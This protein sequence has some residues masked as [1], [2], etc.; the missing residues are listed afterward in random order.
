M[1]LTR[2]TDKLVSILDSATGAVPR[3]LNFFV[4]RSKLQVSNFCDPTTDTPTQV[5]TALAAAIAAA[6][7]SGRALEFESG[8]VYNTNAV[9]DLLGTA[10]LRGLRFWG[11]GAT[12]WRSSGAGKVLTLDSGADTDRCDDIEFIDFR[13]R[14]NALSTYALYT[15]GLGRSLV[16][17]V[18]AVD[19][20]SAGF[21]VEWSVCTD[22]KR[23]MMSDNVDTFAFPAA[24]GLI[25]SDSDLGDY[26]ADCLFESVKFEGTTAISDVGIEIAG[27]AG[28]S[29]TFRL[30]TCE[31]LVCGFRT[32][33]GTRDNVIDGM[34]FEA[35]TGYD[36]SIAGKGLTLRDVNASSAG[37]TGTTVV[38]ATA[39]STT[40]IGGYNRWVALNPASKSTRFFGTNVDNY[41]TLGITGATAG[42]LPAAGIFQSFGVKKTSSGSY[43]ADFPDACGEA[44][45]WTPSIA[46]AGGGAQGAVTTAA[47]RYN[48]VGKICH[49]SGAISIA[50][51]TLGAGAVSIA[52][53]PFAAVNAANAYH[54]LH[55]EWSSINLGAG[56]SE[57]KLRLAPNNSSAELVK[58]G[59]SVTSSGVNLADVPDPLVLF[60]SGTYETA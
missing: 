41:A 6:K 9:T 1:S 39:E 57:L 21:R 55:V 27:N 34:D 11:N 2:V 7:A 35:N 25:V 28:L 54:Y 51:G 49:V 5:A 17:A 56:F 12:I 13:L 52:G 3:T 45:G 60:F 18:R 36:I 8:A 31:G 37:S 40:F 20:A 32:L 33:V 4:R 59:T 48:R 42:S 53:F 58:T 16:E 29:N 43:V 26:T 23:I 19:V 10:G 38:Q 50:K 24:K 22:F 44:G 46:S 15:R 30:G 47:G 14:G